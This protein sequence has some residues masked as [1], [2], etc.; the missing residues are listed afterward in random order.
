MDNKED[1]EEDEQPSIPEEQRTE[2]IK[3]V[4][5]MNAIL[6]RLEKCENID[7]R[8]LDT[9]AVATSLLEDQLDADIPWIVQE[10]PADEVPPPPPESIDNI[11]VKQHGQAHNTELKFMNDEADPP[12]PDDLKSW[13]GL[14][15]DDD[16][17]S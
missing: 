13:F 17:G 15:T 16:D 10:L 6:S 2:M 4:E 5:R 9:L 14:E 12:S 8:V 11:D 7:R 3:A 1:E